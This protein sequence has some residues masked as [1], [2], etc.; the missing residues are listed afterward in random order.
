MSCP[1]NPATSL[2]ERLCVDMIDKETNDSVFKEQSAKIML[3][4]SRLV[5]ELEGEECYNRD[6][7]FI[8]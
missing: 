6:L 2:P 5:S 7:Y 8:T 1:E 3:N 4:S